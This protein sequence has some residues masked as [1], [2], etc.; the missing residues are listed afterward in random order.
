M[1]KCLKCEA[2]SAAFLAP[3]AGAEFHLGFRMRRVN[4][5]DVEPA[6]LGTPV[7]CLATLSSISFQQ[8]AWMRPP[9]HWLAPRWPV[10]L[11][12]WHLDS[13]LSCGGMAVSRLQICSW[14]HKT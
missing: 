4:G 5:S 3:G 2:F 8:A 6:G 7:N 11:A 13:P 14:L 1:V 12:V 9:G 10:H